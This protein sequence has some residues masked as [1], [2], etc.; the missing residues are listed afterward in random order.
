MLFT[1]SVSIFRVDIIKF[2][3]R[4]GL[5]S[6][7]S[8]MPVKIKLSHILLVWMPRTVS[9]KSLFS[10]LRRSTSDETI[11]NVEG[12]QHCASVGCLFAGE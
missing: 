10:F 7:F 9:F 2:L 3:T 1:E 8:G 11:V 4:L 6:A 12:A 5:F